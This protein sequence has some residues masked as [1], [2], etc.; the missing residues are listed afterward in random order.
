MSVSSTISLGITAL[1]LRARSALIREAKRQSPNYFAPHIP[2]ATLPWKQ[3]AKGLVLSVIR[4]GEGGETAAGDLQPGMFMVTPEGL[5]L[6]LAMTN[7]GEGGGD[8]KGNPVIKM[9]QRAEAVMSIV[10][11]DK[12]QVWTAAALKSSLTP[13]EGEDDAAFAHVLRHLVNELRLVESRPGE[14]MYY[15]QQ[16]DLEN[17]RKSLR[18]DIDQSTDLYLMLNSIGT[19]LGTMFKSV[20]LFMYDQPEN[21]QSEVLTVYSAA[22]SGEE[23]VTVFGESKWEALGRQGRFE[24]LVETKQ[25]HIHFT[26]VADVAKAPE[27]ISRPHL[28]K[29]L[30]RYQETFE[31]PGEIFFAVIRT[32][33][34]EGRVLGFLELHR[35][36]KIGED[37][38]EQPLFSSNTS[39]TEMCRQLVSLAADVIAPALDRAVGSDSVVAKIDHATRELAAMSSAIEVT[40]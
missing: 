29:L 34:S 9:K 38:P 6:H 19:H 24:Y 1:K 10:D 13:V 17:C 36:N 12:D 31:N 5:L 14:Y 21:K 2:V 25:S 37:R 32:T 16:A 40:A 22:E 26:N 15:D 20:R 39:S 7:G 11:G 3:V 4:P 30:K 35:W 33:G 23:A 8:G 27:G 18:A 28:K